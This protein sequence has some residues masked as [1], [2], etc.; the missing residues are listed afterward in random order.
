MRGRQHHSNKETNTE[1]EGEMPGI[2]GQEREEDRS[3]DR[4]EMEDKIRDEW[5]AENR[6]FVRVAD[7]KQYA[8]CPRVIYYEYCLPGIRPVTYKMMQGLEA[9]SRVEELE[10]RRGVREYHLKQG[11]RHF[12]VPLTSHR[13]GCTAQIDLVVES[14]IEETRKVIPV[15]FK[16]SRREPGRHVQ[17]QLACYGMMIEEAWNV[18]IPEGIIYLIP[19]K[20]AVRIKLDRRLR[21]EAERAIAEIR[22]IVQQERMPGPTSNRGRCVDCE[23][24]R[25][26]NDIF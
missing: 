5:E 12:Y 9:Q 2:E 17:L 7:I 24:R 21:K 14:D 3:G 8:Y 26:C 1:Q 20:R 25:F 22:A 10:K 15:D 18:E 13:L 11:S 16:M 23:F 4:W 6:W 19:L